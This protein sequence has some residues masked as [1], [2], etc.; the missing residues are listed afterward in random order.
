MNIDLSTFGID[1]T[2]IFPLITADLRHLGMDVLVDFLQL[3]RAIAVVEQR[4]TQ[5][6]A[7]ALAGFVVHR[8]S[9]KPQIRTDIDCRSNVAQGQHQGESDRRQSPKRRHGFYLPPN[10]LHSRPTRSL[11]AEKSELLLS[12]LRRRVCR[13]EYTAFSRQKGAGL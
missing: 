12:A 4:L 7:E 13:D 5:G 6:R 2:G 10:M 8:V 1:V 9:R 11:I 3:L